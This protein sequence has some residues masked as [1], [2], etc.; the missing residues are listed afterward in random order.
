MSAAERPDDIQRILREVTESLDAFKR[1]SKH[2]LEEDENEIY[3]KKQK[4]VQAHHTSAS[5]SSWAKSTTKRPQVIV[6]SES[7]PTP[8]NL[9]RAE[10]FVKTKCPAITIGERHK[11]TARNEDDVGASYDVKIDL[12]S[13]KKRTRGFTIPVA[14]AG[15]V[16]SAPSPSERICPD[17][18]RTIGVPSQT[19]KSFSFGKA[20]RA[21]SDHVHTVSHQPLN[22]STADKWV[23]ER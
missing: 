10:N 22:P 18:R 19:P 6:N 20:A 11:L 5:S 17:Q 13:T 16:S 12:L 7:M 4:P 15:A 2:F 14:K 23:R 3:R 8:L 21:S 1:E 9:L